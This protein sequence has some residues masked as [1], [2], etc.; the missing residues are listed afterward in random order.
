MSKDLK[1]RMLFAHPSIYSFIGVHSLFLEAVNQHANL[2]LGLF[3][4]ALRGALGSGFAL[5]KLTDTFLASGSDPDP[6][7][8]TEAPARGYGISFRTHDFQCSTVNSWANQHE[9][10]PTEAEE[11]LCF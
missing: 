2:A 6:C 10:F 11:S 7:R 8:V 9:G 4:V 5:S 3:R 1:E